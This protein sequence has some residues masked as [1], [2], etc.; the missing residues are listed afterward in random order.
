MNESLLYKL[1]PRTQYKQI[2]LSLLSNKQLT[3]QA[4]TPQI[5]RGKIIILFR[6]ENKMR[7]EKNTLKKSVLFQYQSGHY[8]NLVKKYLITC[9]MCAQC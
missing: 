9:L 5:Q 7:L 1:L 6:D 4:I 8:Y 2:N 3:K